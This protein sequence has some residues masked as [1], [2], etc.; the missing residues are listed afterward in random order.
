VVSVT[1]TFENLTVIGGLL[2]LDQLDALRPGMR[3]SAGRDSGRR[4]R[5]SRGCE[6]FP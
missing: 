4:D 1:V 6:A 5:I 2:A 3:V